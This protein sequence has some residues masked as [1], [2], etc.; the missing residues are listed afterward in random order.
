MF[1][2]SKS[3]HKSTS[4]YEPKTPKISSISLPDDRYTPISFQPAYTEKTTKRNSFLKRFSTPD[5]R[6]STTPMSDSWGSSHGVPL[7]RSRSRTNSTPVR[8]VSVEAPRPIRPHPSQGPIVPVTEHA[9]RIYIDPSRT[10]LAPVGVPSAAYLEEQ[11]R[12][13]RPDLVK[14]LPPSSK[15]SVEDYDPKMFVRSKKLSGIAVKSKDVNIWS[16]IVL[17]ICSMCH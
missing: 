4:S 13:E 8:D 3:A 7:G 12:R 10:G 9:D 11:L 14:Y 1:K 16:L 5:R 2:W 17:L 6:G 15:H